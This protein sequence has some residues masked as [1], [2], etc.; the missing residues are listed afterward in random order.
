MP[1]GAR[2]RVALVPEPCGSVLVHAERLCLRAAPLVRRRAERAPGGSGPP[3]ANEAG[4]NRASRRG[5]H[6]SD[7]TVF[8][9]RR[10]L[11]PR[12]T[13]EP[14]ASGTPVASSG[15]CVS[16][17]FFERHA[18]TPRP[19]R[20][21]PRGPRE[22]RALCQSRVPSAGSR[23]AHPARAEARTKPRSLPRRRGAHVMRIAELRGT[24]PLLPPAEP[25]RLRA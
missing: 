1:F 10:F 11:P 15:P 20:P 19:P 13:E 25:L 14:I 21:V 3:D 22:R 18:L 9:R 4:E 8:T 16:S 24:T 6:F 23:D 17:L 2:P 12:E 5:S 7:R